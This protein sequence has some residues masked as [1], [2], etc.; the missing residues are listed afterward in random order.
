MYLQSFIQ[1]FLGLDTTRTQYFLDV[2]KVV[3]W[4]VIEQVPNNQTHCYF[5]ENYVYTCLKQNE[6]Q[7]EFHIRLGSV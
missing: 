1:M 3:R 5:L 2:R 6:E 7:E 4:I